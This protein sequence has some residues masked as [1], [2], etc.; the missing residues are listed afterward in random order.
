M[1]LFVKIHIAGSYNSIHIGM[2]K[3]NIVFNVHPV[4]TVLL[5]LTRM[6]L[7]LYELYR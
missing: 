1:K 2:R 6:A 4:R 3:G 5:I 7:A